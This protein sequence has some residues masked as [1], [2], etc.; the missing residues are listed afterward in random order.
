MNPSPLA[1]PAAERML[2]IV[3]ECRLLLAVTLH[4]PDDWQGLGLLLEQTGIPAVEVM[5]RSPHAWQGIRCLRQKWPGLVLGVGT[6]L[7]PTDVKRAQDEGADFAVSP[8][9]RLDLLEYAATHKF[10]YLPGAM[11]P[12][13]LM[14]IASCGWRAVKFFPAAP[15]GSEYLQVLA[16]PF[17]DLRF[18]VSGGLEVGNYREFLRVRQVAALSGSWPLP[19]N[20]SDASICEQSLP[21]LRDLMVELQSSLMN[22]NL[23]FSYGARP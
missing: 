3:R 11:H 2:D 6:V 1:N 13:D 16:A 20:L 10:P 14:L 4:R 18:C 17:P 15:L 12:S 19:R 5:L 23:Q 7:N 21:G 9:T 8:G 22:E